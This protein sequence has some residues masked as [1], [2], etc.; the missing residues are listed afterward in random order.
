[1]A[2]PLTPDEDGFLTEAALPKIL[3]YAES[4]SAVVIGCGL[5]RTD[6]VKAL[7]KGLIEQLECPIILDADGLNAIADC[8]DILQKAKSSVVLTPHSGELSRLLNAPLEDVK[9]NRLDSAR[10]IAQRFDMTVVHKGAGTVVATKNHAY[11][12]TTGNSGMSKG[13]SGDV[14]A[15]IITALMARRMPQCSEGRMPSVHA[16]AY[17]A[18]IHGLAGIRAA[19]RRGENCTL[20]TD[21][22][23]CIRLDDEGVI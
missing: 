5:G 8:I 16:A 7:V 1:M 3:K 9:I 12:N 10:A 20:P 22:V 19:K 23:D 11:I 21:V 14:L 18:L 2:L 17:G 4:C 13:G 15:G 6:S